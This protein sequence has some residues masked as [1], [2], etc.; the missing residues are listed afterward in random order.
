M[1]E[2]GMVAKV[3]G[4]VRSCDVVCGIDIVMC[5]SGMVVRGGCMLVW[6]NRMVVRAAGIVVCDGGVRRRYGGV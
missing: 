6:K 3:V 5:E 1:C 2:S 4:G